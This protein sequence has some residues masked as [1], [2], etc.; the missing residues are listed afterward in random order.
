[1]KASARKAASPSKAA[2]AKPKGV[3][4]V[5][6]GTHAIT[7]HVVVKDAAAAIAFY[8]R[9]FGAVELCRMPGPNGQGVM[10]AEMRIGDS[11]FYLC[12]ESPMNDVRAPQSV[13]GTTI[14]MH[15]YV[16]DVDAVFQQAVSAGAKVVM[17]P[18]DMFW[19]DRYGK[20]ADPFGHS[21]A[22]A[23][24]K[25]DVSPEQMAVRAEQAFSAPSGGDVG[26]GEPAAPIEE[27]ALF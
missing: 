15:V 6:E 14:A 11:P 22:L 5:P 4:H 2:R 24:H 8:T 12:D 17:P 19:G 10:H 7:P 1:M 3:S 16:P 9:A 21:W 13:G 26:G 25:E 27:P 23:T 18:M 20:V